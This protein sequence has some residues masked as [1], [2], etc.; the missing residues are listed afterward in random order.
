MRKSVRRTAALFSI[1]ALFLLSPIPKTLV[2]AQTVAPVCDLSPVTPTLTINN[3]NNNSGWQPAV[4]SPS[5]GKA[6][7]AIQ[8]TVTSGAAS[9]SGAAFGLVSSIG[10]ENKPATLLTGAVTVVQTPTT[11]DR[12]LQ[13]YITRDSVNFLFN[14]TIKLCTAPGTGGTGGG[15]GGTVATA[16]TKAAPEACG[17]GQDA[18]AIAATNATN[19]LPINGFQQAERLV[20]GLT[21]NSWAPNTPNPKAKLDF[22]G[23]ATITKISAHS[24]FNGDTG[25]KITNKDAPNQSWTLAPTNGQGWQAPLPI[26]AAT[27]TGVIVE[28]AKATGS[29]TELVFCVGTGGGGT[30]GGGGGTGGGGTGGG[31]NTPCVATPGFTECDTITFTKADGSADPRTFLVPIF[32]ESRGTV[33]RSTPL[34]GVQWTPNVAAGDT[35]TAV[36]HNKW[37]VQ[38]P[39]KKYYPSWHP[40]I[41]PKNG[42]S[43]GHEHGESPYDSPIYKFSGGVP[44]GYTNVVAG[45]RLEEDH[46]GHKIIKQSNWK[47]I[48]NNGAG[49][50]TQPK[51]V[52]FTCNW[53]SH[54]HQGTHSGDAVDQN[55]HEY[56]VNLVCNDGQARFPNVPEPLNGH[57]RDTVLSIKLLTSFGQPGSTQV[58]GS[59]QPFATAGASGKTAL[60]P[61]ARRVIACVGDLTRAQY[62]VEKFINQTDAPG[63]TETEARDSGFQELWRPGAFIT[64]GISDHEVVDISPYYFVYDPSRL[65]NNSIDGNTELNAPASE[66]YLNDS[67]AWIK[68]VEVCSLEPSPNAPASFKIGRTNLCDRLASIFGVPATP[69]GYKIIGTLAEDPRS[70]F[71]GIKRAIHPKGG[72]VKNNLGSEYLCTAPDGTA[73]RVAAISNG[74]PQCRAGELPQRLAQTNNLWTYETQA[75][76]GRPGATVNGVIQGSDVSTR[77]GLTPGEGFE[78]V[79]LNNDLVGRDKVH[80]PN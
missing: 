3:W 47:G 22:G 9:A 57:D 72:T 65:A 69:A 24:W 53:L 61:E 77:P 29:I 52:G 37:W 27:M 71:K 12:T 2:L 56:N 10:S 66:R 40:P 51:P 60:D 19:V 73:P 32:E 17:V 6:V 28:S 64:D 31:G 41:D 8:I 38:G 11:S 23:T 76:W 1:P 4:N 16:P 46:V 62:N 54:I 70:P 80:A 5:Q 75:S 63:P 33:L 35:C 25:I 78:W 79:R 34:E 59:E 49:P 39:D 7:V 42:C 20:D 67:R 43:Y 68:T 13:M 26:G 15:G 21:S 14:A 58:C 18:V 45:D 50:P 48:A 36:D 55:Q 74:L 44:F 30:G